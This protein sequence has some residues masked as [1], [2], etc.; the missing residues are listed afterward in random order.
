[1][2]V[3]IYVISFNEKEC[4]AE[5]YIRFNIPELIRTVARA[6]GR[7]RYIKIMKFVKSRF[8]KVFLLIIDNRYEVIAR[9]LIPIAGPAYYITASEVITMNYLR[10]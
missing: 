8:N 10:T 7:D 2:A 5:R 3:L 1:M 4:I 6:V 9:I